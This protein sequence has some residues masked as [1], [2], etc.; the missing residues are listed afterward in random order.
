MPRK[1]VLPSYDYRAPDVRLT[2]ERQNYNIH[3]VGHSQANRII[4]FFLPK[5]AARTIVSF[6]IE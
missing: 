4:V 6:L 2:C 5:Q 3:V 1:T